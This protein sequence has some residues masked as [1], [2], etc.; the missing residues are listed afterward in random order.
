MPEA[1]TPQFRVSN[2]GDPI[3]PVDPEDLRRRWNTQ[4]WDT[5]ALIA[6]RIREVDSSAIARR[7]YMLRMLSQAFNKGQ[8]LTPWQHRAELDDAVFRIAATFPIRPLRQD[9]YK[10]P[11]DEMWGFD[12]N[13][14]VQKLIDET[15]ISHVW[16]PV[17][18]K[19]TKGNCSYR[20]IRLGS[21]NPQGPE[22]TEREAKYE[23]RQLLWAVWSKCQP[24]LS[25]L[26][27]NHGEHDVPVIAMQFADFAIDNVA[28]AR[29][30]V[31]PR[32]GGEH[33]DRLTMLLE[34]ER[35][36]TWGDLECT[37]CQRL[38]YEHSDREMADCHNALPPGTTM[39][40]F[41]TS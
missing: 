10:V 21:G 1:E 27:P 26:S 8:L 38:M 11:G 12:P 9:V 17:L 7:F 25:R 32:N 3:P 39:Y 13:A 35:R 36:A 19:M 29:E 20:T 33:R 30:F 31:S 34:L 24:N 23:A 4:Q 28:L 37:V 6:E 14:F 40:R 18:T 41:S 5:E 15:G 16:E 2:E 22:D